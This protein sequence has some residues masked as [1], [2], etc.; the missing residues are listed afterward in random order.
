LIPDTASG[1]PEAGGQ[2]ADSYRQDTTCGIF[3]G[4]PINNAGVAKRYTQRTQN[5][6]NR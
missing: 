2:V 6:S 3:V 5:L 1:G 4:K